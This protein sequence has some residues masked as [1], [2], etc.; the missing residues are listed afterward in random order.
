MTTKMEAVENQRVVNE[1]CRTLGAVRRRCAAAGIDDTVVLNEHAMRL[2]SL[3]DRSIKEIENAA[4]RRRHSRRSAALA[5]LLRGEI[6]S[7]A[8]VFEEDGVVRRGRVCVELPEAYYRGDGR[9]SSCGRTWLEGA[10]AGLRDEP[11]SCPFHEVRTDGISNRSAR[12]WHEG[13]AAAVEAAK[14]SLK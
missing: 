3:D 1:W 5:A 14:E 11:P 4:V 13:H 7:D 2:L 10:A 9:V 6:D 8:A 12:S